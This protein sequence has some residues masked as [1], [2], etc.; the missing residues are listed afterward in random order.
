MKIGKSQNHAL[1]IDELF[2]LADENNRNIR[3]FS[4]AVQEAEASVKTAKNALLPSIDASLSLSYNSNGLITDRNF[5]NSFSAPIP[6]F[7]NNFS[8]E[9]SQVV[10]AGGA[11][12]NT[13][14]I[15]GLQQQIATLNAERKRQEVHFLITGYYL[16]LCKLKNQLQVFESNIA[17]TQKVLENM[18][19]RVGEGTALQNDITRYELQL[20]NLDYTKIQLQNSI[21]LLNSQLTTAAGLPQS[22]I[23]VP[24]TT[25]V[26]ANLKNDPIPDPTTAL[27]VQIAETTGK[28]AVHTEKISRA[29]RLPQIVLFAGDY[30]NSP[31][32][33][34]IPAL[35]KNFNYWTVGIGIKYSLG[36]LYKSGAKIRAS[37]LA[38][39]RANEE[40]AVIE[41]QV[42]LA[43]DDAFVHY[44]EAFTLLKTKEKSI[45][46]A[47][48]NYHVIA[49]RYENDLALI[50]DLLDA[51][52]QK[53]DAE[54][55]A[56]NARINIVYN[57][58]K[59][60]YISG[61]L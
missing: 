33:I 7:G 24:D 30:L 60:K 42:S 12:R 54:L 27:A 34:E 43:L 14:K 16:E 38:T 49:Y 31:V 28:I 26:R 17:Q 48:R 2:R 50:T 35:N 41:E 45:E 11:I 53:L 6:H 21:A 9:V 25:I 18:R 52:S 13:V 44:K 4:T 5:S 10:F 8:L 61:T 39:R 23:I 32:T 55:Q 47:T 57:Y 36:N 22:V 19:M 56:V 58:Y 40:K 29:E 51:A 20:Q 1:S 37:R 59:L 15:A 46:L 3:V